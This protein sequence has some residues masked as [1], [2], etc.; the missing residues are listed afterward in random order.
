[1]VVFD[2]K[3]STKRF[4]T[5]FRKLNNISKKSSWPL[6]VTDDMLATLGKEKYFTTLDLKSG[7]WQIPPTEKYKE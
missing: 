3:D 2:R 7:Y 6:P 5:D 4:C 1:M